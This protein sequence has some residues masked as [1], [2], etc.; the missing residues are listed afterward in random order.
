M[1]DRLSEAD[2]MLDVC[3]KNGTKLAIAHQRR[4]YPGWTEARRLISEGAIVQNN[5]T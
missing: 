1:A 3:S 4:F 2:Q 5:Y